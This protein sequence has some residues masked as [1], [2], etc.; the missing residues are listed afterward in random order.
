MSSHETMAAVAQAKPMLGMVVRMKSGVLDDKIDYDPGMLGLIV[1]IDTDNRD[2]MYSFHIDTRPFD[3]HN[4]PLMVANY[5][6]DAG[7]PTLTAKDAGQW[8]D[9]AVYYIAPYSLVETRMEF[10]GSVPLANSHIRNKGREVIVSMFENDRAFHDY[11]KTDQK[12]IRDDARA[13]ADL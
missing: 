3:D 11:T 7:N 10:L 5:Y 9:V 2:D 1:Q 8:K 12:T 6:D 13:I 4:D